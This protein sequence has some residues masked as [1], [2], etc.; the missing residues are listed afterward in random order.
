MCQ[1]SNKTTVETTTR[2]KPMVR[3]QGTMCVATYNGTTIVSRE[4]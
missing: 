2:N 1:L 3:L 4:D